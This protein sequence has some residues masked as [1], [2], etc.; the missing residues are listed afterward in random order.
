MKLLVLDKYGE[1]CEQ[2]RRVLGYPVL[3]DR[4]EAVMLLRGKFRDVHT[5]II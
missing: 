4:A 2:L 1:L 5:T 3:C